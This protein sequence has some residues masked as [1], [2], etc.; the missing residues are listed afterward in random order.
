[1]N[2]ARR[3]ELMELLDMAQELQPRLEA[4]RDEEQEAFDNMP[5]GLQGSE[6]GEMTQ[7]AADALDQAATAIEE[8][9]TGLDEASQY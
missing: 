9:V 4:L 7:A 8:V 1:M 5:E 6:R 2:K 3:K